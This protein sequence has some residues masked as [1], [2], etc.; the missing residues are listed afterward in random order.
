MA[1]ATPSLIVGVGLVPAEIFQFGDGVA[2]DDW[3]AGEGEHFQIV[4]VVADGHDFFAGV[5]ADGRPI[6]QARSLCEISGRITSIIEKL[7]D[8]DGHGQGEFVG[9]RGCAQ[10]A[11]PP[12]AFRLL[13]P[14]NITWMGSSVRQLSSGLANAIEFA[15]AGVVAGTDRVV[16][17][18]DFEDDLVGARAIE[19]DAGAFAPG[20]RDLQNASRRVF[21]QE[22]AE[23]GFA[24]GGADQRAVVADHGERRV[25]HA[26]DGHGEIVAA[27]GD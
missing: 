3:D 9:E 12:R 10:D 14:E 15:I 2:H 23:M 20:L 1:A 26:G 5:A 11:I 22:M 7:R 4:V 25:E 16:S 17:V 18:D 13:L 27:A 6:R 24:V 8:V 21:R 19:D